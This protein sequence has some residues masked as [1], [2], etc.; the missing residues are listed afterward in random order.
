MEVPEAL[1]YLIN[2]GTSGRMTM[3]SM[4]SR[5]S[6]TAT[7]NKTSFLWTRKAGDIAVGCELLP[8]ALLAAVRLEVDESD[9]GA[10]VPISD[11]IDLTNI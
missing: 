3:F 9:S 7:M 4:P 6:A 10:D 2:S 5:S 8:V 11:F 1:K